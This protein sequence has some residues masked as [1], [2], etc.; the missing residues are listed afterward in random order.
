[1]ANATP[2]RQK[3]K[4]FSREE[5]DSFFKKMN[6]GDGLFSPDPTLGRKDPVSNWITTSGS[7]KQ[8]NKLTK[9]SAWQTG[10]AS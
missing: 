4:K 5:I 1:M 9:I 7:S 10:Q 3:M 8:N 6:R 2:P